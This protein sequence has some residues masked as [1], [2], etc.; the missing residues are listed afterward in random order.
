[1]VTILPTFPFAFVTYYCFACRLGDN[2]N[3]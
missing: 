1:M 2:N 3:I